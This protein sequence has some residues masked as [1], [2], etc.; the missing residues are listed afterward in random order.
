MD[1]K[2]QYG[3]DLR[4]LKIGD[5]L[6]SADSSKTSHAIAIGTNGK[7]SHA[8]LYVGN[9]VIHA[10]PDGLYAKNPQR[11]VAEAPEHLMALRLRSNKKNTDFESICNHA[12]LQVG[13]LYSIPEAA[14]AKFLSN[15]EKIA[16]T[17]KQFCSRLIAQSYEAAGI[18][19]VSNSDYCS[20]NDIFR[21]P[22]LTPIEGYL[23][24]MSANELAF[25]RTPDFTVTIMNATYT[26]LEQTRNLARRRGLGSVSTHK[27][28]SSLLMQNPELDK[29]IS[30]YVIESGYLNFYNIDRKRNGYRYDTASFLAVCKNKTHACEII[31]S[32]QLLIDEEMPRRIVAAKHAAAIYSI[33]KLKYFKLE[34]ELACNILN[35]V[36]IRQQIIDA[37]KDSFKSTKI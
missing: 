9:S 23:K 8:M 27:D 19:I 20:P 1:I 12:R 6:L 4:S 29:Q 5:I 22:L 24:E 33:Y 13:A 2:K 11:I 26:W 35:E 10:M 18:E 17:D 30:D 37:V 36:A 14:R 21:S 28:V 32:E 15:K 31:N 25:A 34:Y 7:F 3:F 16:Q